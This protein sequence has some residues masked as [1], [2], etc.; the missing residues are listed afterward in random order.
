MVVTGSRR[1]PRRGGRGRRARGR[2][3][4]R[5]RGR[6]PTSSR[7]AGPARAP[8]RTGW[9]GGSGPSTGR[10]SPA[11]SPRVPLR[12][13][14]RSRVRRGGGP[15]WS[16][17]PRLHPPVGALCFLDQRALRGPGPQT[18]VATSPGTGRTGRLTRGRCSPGRASARPS[19]PR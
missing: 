8:R 6:A 12:G 14:S 13:S 9:P 11:G 3:R 19:C 7:A 1:D 18:Q 5:G 16:S 2:V 15:W 4:G 17:G 10:P